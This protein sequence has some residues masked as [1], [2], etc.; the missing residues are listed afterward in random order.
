MSHEVLAVTGATIVTC[1]AA[2]SVVRDGTMVVA[3]GRIVAVGPAGAVT[4]PAGARIVDGRD[5]ILMPG[6]INMHCHAGDSLFRG[7]VEDLP[8][9]P[10]LQTVWKAERA[11]LTAD[12]C[13]LGARLGLAELALQGVTTVMDMF[14]HIDETVAAA[15]EIG[16]RVATGGIFFDPPGM[17]GRDADGR[18][19]SAEGFCRRHAGNPFV[20]TGVMPHA[21]YTVGPAS[22]LEAAEVARGHDGFFC[23]HAAETLAEQR[24]IE[25]RYGARVIVHLDRLDLLGP[26]TVLAHCVHIDA[27]EI[28]LLAA[29][30]THVVHNPMSNLKLASG[31]APVPALMAAGVNVSLGTDGAISGNDIDLW[32][33][34]RLAATLHKAATGDAAAVPTAEALRMATVNGAKALRA[35]HR[36]GSLEAGK[37]ADFILVATDRIHAAPLFDPVTHLVY[38]A[39]KADVTDVFVAGRQLVDAGRLTTADVP[40]LIGEVHG[41]RAATLASIG[42]AG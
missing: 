25:E 29:S 34:L 28:R 6:L 16:V 24:T 20:F 36:L 26:R 42:R 7:L 18:R 5:R 10:W 21:T 32:L 38:A 23:T 31:F 27:E 15:S 3:D 37:D 4:V 1:D 35:E 41:L 13:R 9:E 22:L 40:A 17:D 39:G 14:W 30:G 8:L 19:A 33:A 11:I 12:T 2:M